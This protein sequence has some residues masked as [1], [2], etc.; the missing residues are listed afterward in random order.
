VNRYLKWA[1]AEAAKSAA[2]NHLR[3]PERHVS[4]LYFRLRQRKGHQKAVGAVARHLAESAYQVLRREEPYRD[5]V[6]RRD[7]TAGV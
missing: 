5:P 1:F 2:V 7:C 6:Q 3:C 4:R